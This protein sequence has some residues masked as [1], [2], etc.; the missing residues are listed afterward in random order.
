MRKLEQCQQTCE[1]SLRSGG[2]QK[3]THWSGQISTWL[4]SIDGYLPPFLLFFRTVLPSLSHTCVVLIMSTLTNM[5][6]RASVS[7]G[8][9]APLL[10]LAFYV[11]P[12]LSFF[13]FFFFFSSNYYRK[14]QGSNSHHSLHLKISIIIPSH[15]LGVIVTSQI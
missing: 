1:R 9:H 4:E 15:T 5:I 10:S 8:W 14:P 7:R 3:P 13:F 11:S 12:P 2:V 6:A